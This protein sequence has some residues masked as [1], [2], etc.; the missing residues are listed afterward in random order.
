LK[1]TKIIEMCVVLLMVL[2]T[3]A[4]TSAALTPTTGLCPSNNGQF[5]LH[6]AG[7]GS[8]PGYLADII[9]FNREPNEL[10][11]GSPLGP[12]FTFQEGNDCYFGANSSLHCGL[13]LYSDSAL[14]N[15]IGTGRIDSDQL[16][17]QIGSDGYTYVGGYMTLST[18][19][20]NSAPGNNVTL[21]NF[22]SQ[23]NVQIYF[24][25]TRL[26]P[27]V[28]TGQP[29]LVNTLQISQ[30]GL[31]GFLTVWGSDGWNGTDYVPSV[32]HTGFDFRASLECPQPNTTHSTFPCLAI[33]PRATF[34][35]PQACIDNNQPIHH[36]S[37][38]NVISV[39]F[40]SSQNSA[41]D[42]GCTDSDSSSSS[43]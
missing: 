13:N 9:F 24:R 26:F 4:V 17:T 34:V 14:S 22:R 7:I 43:W 41:S 11:W 15:L 29:P 8:T 42:S 16:F 38:L 25:P 31:G 28:S 30:D 37:P 10:E 39:S 5:L 36:Y 20:T 40:S 18:N 19:I 32:R 2:V 21:I 6:F 27:D 23:S 35:V 12:Y 1:M 33:D 3:A